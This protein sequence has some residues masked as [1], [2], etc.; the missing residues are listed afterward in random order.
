MTDDAANGNGERRKDG[1]SRERINEIGRNYYRFTRLVLILFYIQ[2]ASLFAFG[3]LSVYLTNE[4][5]KRADENAKLIITIQEERKNAFISSCQDQ[6]DRHDNTI[7]LLQ[8]NGDDLIRKQP[9]RTA[10]IRN[11]IRLSIL[12]IDAIIPKRNCLKLANEAV[13]TP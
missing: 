5:H 6:N 9:E 12:L 7:Q 11:S 3:I 13:K 10:E 1:L 8:K 2:V 4:N